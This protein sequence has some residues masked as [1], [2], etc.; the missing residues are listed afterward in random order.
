MEVCLLDGEI[1]I[2][3][4]FSSATLYLSAPTFLFSSR[5]FL[6]IFPRVSSTRGPRGFRTFHLIL[7]IFEIGKKIPRISLLSTFFIFELPYFLALSLWVNCPLS[8]SLLND[9]KQTKKAQSART[10][11]IPGCEIGN[12]H[13]KYWKNT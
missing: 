1:E 3:R 4:L 8:V 5:I 10:T 7:T 12:F 11:W 2:S 9:L 6:V 13:S